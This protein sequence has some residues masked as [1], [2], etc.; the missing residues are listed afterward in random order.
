[1]QFLLLNREGENVSPKNINILKITEV[2]VR[3]RDEA[4]QNCVTD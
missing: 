3:R 1:M 4:R 2:R